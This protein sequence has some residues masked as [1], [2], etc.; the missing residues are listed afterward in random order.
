MKSM[1]LHLT[2]I[3]ILVL[4]SFS[5]KSQVDTCWTMVYPDDILNGYSNPD[6]VLY[7][8]CH[9]K[10]AYNKGCDSVY[11][12]QWFEFS[13]MD[14]DPYNFP[15]FPPDTIIET[16]WQNLDSNYVELRNLFQGLENIFG[17]F[18]LRKEFPDAVDP[19]LAA[20]AYIIRFDNYV[21]IDS[22]IFYL[23]NEL[24]EKIYYLNNAAHL[25]SNYEEPNSTKDIK[26]YPNPCTTYTNLFLKN[27]FGLFIIKLYGSNGQ[28]I[29]DISEPEN[30][31]NF[32]VFKINTTQF[33]NGLYFVVIY[34]M[35]KYYIIKLIVIK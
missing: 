16:T 33:S 20:R 26:L 19:I 30:S 12:K 9:C 2:S 31:D 24:I 13:F 34:Y 27:Y 10:D 28:F 17:K 21:N 29:E 18:I 32:T 22:V 15:S 23:S 35:N 3:F 7:D 1:R 11:A 6:S 14:N 8:S 25:L 4:I 5:A